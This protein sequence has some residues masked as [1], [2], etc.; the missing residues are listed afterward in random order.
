MTAVTH[1]TQI[2]P[3]SYR[4][5]HPVVTAALVTLFWLM[6]AIL[7]LTAHVEIAPFSALGGA[8]AT[9]G[10]IVVSAYGYTRCAARHAGITHALG[11][12]IAWLVLSIVVEMA[13]A[14]RLGHGW[15]SLLGSPG[16]ALLRNVTMF[17]WIF[18]PA[19]FAHGQE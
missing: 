1:P 17:A 18:A 14:T 6:A 7:V 19:F 13:L 2:Q 4:R 8:A 11:V 5:H 12:G 15:F 9:L 3:F 10:A 16:H